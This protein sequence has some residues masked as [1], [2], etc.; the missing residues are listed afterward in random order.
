M[1]INIILLLIILDYPSLYEF[2]RFL[3]NHMQ[4]RILYLY[5]MQVELKVKQFRYKC[6]HYNE[7]DQ[8]L[9]QNE[10]NAFPNTQLSLLFYVF[11]S[12]LLD[13]ILLHLQY[14][15]FIFL[16]LYHSKVVFLLQLICLVCYFASLKKRI[17]INVV[18]KN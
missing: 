9:H 17:I 1:L 5:Q 6:I 15:I 12:Q 16:S 4:N 14:L 13:Y 3:F 8:M 11:L 7:F 10:N 2:F 18:Q